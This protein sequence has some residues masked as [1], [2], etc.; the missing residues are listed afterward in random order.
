MKSNDLESKEI[1]SIGNA[2]G[3]S[4]TLNTTIGNLLLY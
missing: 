4:D 1:V 2:G 3:N